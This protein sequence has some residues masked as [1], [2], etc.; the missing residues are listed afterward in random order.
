MP[1]FISFSVSVLCHSTLIFSISHGKLSFLSLILTWRHSSELGNY[2][3]H[4]CSTTFLRIW[5]ETHICLSSSSYHLPYSYTTYWDCWSSMCKSLS[6][7][8]KLS[9]SKSLGMGSVGR[10]SLQSSQLH[11]PLLVLVEGG[12]ASEAYTY[13][14]MYRE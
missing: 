1:A 12:N 8:C 14:S 11:C 4:R 5:N 3:E 7:L 10:T 2:A 6:V 13:L 9:F